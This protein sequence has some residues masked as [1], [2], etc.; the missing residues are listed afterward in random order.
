VDAGGV[1]QLTPTQGLGAHAVPR[2]PQA[3]AVCV[4]VRHVPETQ[5]LAAVATPFVQLAGG[6]G[7]SV[8]A[9]SHVAVPPTARHV[10][11]DA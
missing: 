7:V 9:N 6:Q 3:H 4:G 8:D 2:H 11:V 1:T 10:P 5:L